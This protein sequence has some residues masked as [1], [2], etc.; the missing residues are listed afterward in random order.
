[1]YKIILIGMFVLFVS[2]PSFAQNTKINLQVNNKGFDEIITLLEQNSA[3][4]FFYDRI[5]V[6]SLYFS[7][8]ANNETIEQIL[9]KL[10][11]PQNLTYTIIDANKIVFVKDYKIK[12]NYAE[13]YLRYLEN[14]EFNRADTTEYTLPKPDNEK[15]T[16]NKEY[17]LFT[18]GNPS[19]NPHL[20]TATLRGT[21]KDIETGEPLVGA[22]IYI[23]ELKRGTACNAYGFYSATLPKGQY[24]I[25][26]RLVGMNTTYRNIVIHSDG[27]LDVEMKDKPESLKEVVVT[28]KREDLVRNLRMGVEKLSMKTLKQ[29]PLGFGEADIIKSSLLLPGVQ[30][31]GEA[32]SGF[33]VRGGSVDQNL[34]L[35]NDASI[36]N[37]S[38]FFGFFSGFNSDIVKDITL[39]KSGVPAKY[40]GRASSVM[41]ITLKEGNRKETKVS[42]GIS[43]VSGK[44]NVEGPIKEDKSSF[45]IGARTT[46]SNWILKLLDDDKLKNSTAGFYDVQGNFSFDLDEDNSL[47][48]SGYMSHDNFDYYLEDAFEYNT[49]ASSLKWKHIFSPKLFSTFSA[50]TSNYDYAMQSRIDSTLSNSVKYNINQ[51]SLKADFSYH[52]SKNHKIDFGLNSTYYNLSPGIREPV[53]PLSIVTNKEIE[54]ERALETSLYL[55]DEFELND[56]ISISAGL[57]YTLYGNFGPKTQFNYQ[58]GLPKSVE[59][60][61]DT[62]LYGKGASVKF[63]SGPELR[64]S[65]N[66]KTT[67]S[68]SIK[69]GFSRMHQYIHMMSKT[70]AMSPTDI[71]KLSDNYLKPQR[72]DQV[73]IGFY[74]NLRRNTIEASVETYYKKLKDILDY[75]GG[76]QLV[77]NEHLETDVLNGIGKAYGVELMLQKKTGKFSGWINYTYSRILHKIDSDFEEERVSNG[78]YFPANYDKPHNFKYIFNYK[79]T[80]RFNVSSNFFYSTGRPYTAPI[81]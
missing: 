43:P 32:S 7:F 72:G 69:V 61:K 17:E 66:I 44:L 58:D 77:M 9:D 42:G 50:I 11:K 35:F 15:S 20:K 48:I 22:T 39:Y 18:I 24:R 65:T 4:T 36:L 27:K 37:T 81:A 6:D 53:G 56:F 62:T 12:T 54:K 45:I 57:R 25:E 79:A 34:I 38:H 40:G 13:S 78:E 23:E 41:E 76:A 60:I 80:R 31:V 19:I 3:Y 63:Y 10:S 29:L 64:F 71:W 74:K 52:S 14:Y 47:Y 8:D 73:S 2:A 30:S 1:M 51:S 68:S 21:L 49:F 59:T 5:W 33:N 70:T 55:S 26:Y 75:K 16:I 46:Y 28:A 67:S